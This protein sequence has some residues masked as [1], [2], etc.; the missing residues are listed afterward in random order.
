VNVPD[1]FVATAALAEVLHALRIPY[2]VGGSLASMLYGEWRLTNDVDI[3]IALTS[4]QVDT[5]ARLLERAFIVDRESIAEAVRERGS[6]NAIHRSPWVKMDVYVRKPEG[7]FAE[8]L[9]RALKHQ[10]GDD[11]EQFA[12]FCTPEDIVL[13]KLRWYQLGGGA[14]DRQWRDILGVLK[15]SHERIDCEYLR[16]WA[17]NLGVAALLQRALVESGLT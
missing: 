2:V 8:E 6:F 15:R 9:K 14:S 5:L 7:H 10:V 4:W 17:G 13:Q 1:P 11:A 12:F 3:A 16:A